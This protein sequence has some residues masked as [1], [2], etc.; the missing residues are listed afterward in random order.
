MHILIAGAGTGGLALAHL[1]KQANIEVSIFERDLV[2]NADTGGYRVGISPA[3]SKAL[4][5]CV[6]RDNYE[7]FV[8]TSA[9]APRN[10]TMYTEHFS[11]VLCL[12]I[13]GEAA[14]ATD[15]E[16][17]VIRK[18]LR[19][20]LLKGLED[21][22]HFG[23]RLVS[24]TDDPDGTVTAHFEDGS[25]ASGDVLVGADG[26]GSA[27]RK[28]RLPGARL[29]DTGIVSL[30]GKLPMTPANRALLS[31]QMFYGMSMIMAPRGFGAIIHSLEFTSGRGD[32]TIAARW[33]DFVDALTDDSIG[34]ALWGARQNF[35][36]DPLS[37]NGDELVRLGLELT[38]HWDSRMGQLIRRTAPAMISSLGM[39]TSAPLPPWTSSNVTLVGDAIH[40]M[41]P[42]RGAGANTALR[43][44]MLLGHGLIE[45]DR[46]R[47][48][49]IDAIHDYE[50]EVRRYGAEAVTASKKQVNSADPIHR[51][52]IGRVQLGL[53]RG[54]MRTVNAIPPLKR[55]M[56][57]KIMKVRGAN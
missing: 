39:R 44:A 26:A 34:W 12:E 10:F 17:N 55:H 14:D 13:E 20:V 53:M 9:R 28:Q 49:L 4:K 41:T 18:T 56:L 36:R 38:R 29:E 48:P 8:A 19:R 21:R 40:T 27:V 15:G 37:L 7:L 42:G 25:H 46:G 35:P 31:D 16:K 33:P 23:K 1:L 45:A 3:G 57:R 2:P 5:A 43:D 52:I 30:G 47:K 50:V 24:Y 32:P 22:V 54:G 11:E 6:P 51:P